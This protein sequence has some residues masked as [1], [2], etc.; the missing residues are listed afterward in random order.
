MIIFWYIFS[1]KLKYVYNTPLPQKSNFHRALKANIENIFF[2]EGEASCEAHDML[3][4]TRVR[5]SIQSQR[6]SASIRVCVCV[7]ARQS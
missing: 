7:Q 6:T 1:S 4:S 2:T 3:S 5:W